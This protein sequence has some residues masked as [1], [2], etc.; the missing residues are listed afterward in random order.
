MRLE[1]LGIA[2]AGQNDG[3]GWEASLYRGE[4]N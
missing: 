2:I 3:R 1:R 4:E